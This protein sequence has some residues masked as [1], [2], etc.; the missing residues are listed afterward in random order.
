MEAISIKEL[1]LIV[2]EV[3]VMRNGKPTKRMKKVKETCLVDV[4]YLPIK[5]MDHDCYYSPE[6]MEKYGFS[7]IRKENKEYLKA[8]TKY[9]EIIVSIAKKGFEIINSVDIKIRWEE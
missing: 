9:G 1:K 6:M 8:D 2:K 4:E 5:I 3:P 7:L